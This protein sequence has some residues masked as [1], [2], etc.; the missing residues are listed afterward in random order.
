MPRKA[1]NISGL[2]HCH[3]KLPLQGVGDAPARID[4]EVVNPL[5]LAR[6]GKFIRNRESL[7]WLRLLLVFGITKPGDATEGS[8]AGEIVEVGVGKLD[9]RGPRTSRY[10]YRRETKGASVSQLQGP[11]KS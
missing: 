1:G 11:A 7:R 8:T 5:T 6:F 4:Y 10:R 2:P 9:G 3:D